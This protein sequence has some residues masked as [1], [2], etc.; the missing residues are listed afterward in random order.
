MTAFTTAILP[1]NGV[2]HRVRLLDMPS[3]GDTIRSI[4]VQAAV[5]VVKVT[6]A[7][8][9]LALSLDKDCFAR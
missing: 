7:Q 6:S 9:Q 4:L 8:Y 5:F 3:S 2:H 1:A